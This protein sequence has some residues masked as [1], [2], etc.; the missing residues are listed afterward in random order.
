[1]RAGGW[2]TPNRGEIVISSLQPGFLA[3]AAFCGAIL[4]FRSCG[5]RSP[6]WARNSDDESSLKRTPGLLAHFVGRFTSIIFAML[7]MP[8]QIVAASLRSVLEAWGDETA[9]ARRQIWTAESETA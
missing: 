8:C 7:E 6:A 2:I 1:M 9:Q 3:P 4:P 5:L